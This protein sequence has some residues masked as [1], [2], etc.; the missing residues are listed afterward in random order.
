[1]QFSVIFSFSTS[2]KY[3]PYSAPSIFYT[4]KLSFEP[5]LVNK[6]LQGQ[7]VLSS[8]TERADGNSYL[9]KTGTC[10]LLVASVRHQMSVLKQFKAILLVL[11]MLLLP[12]LW[13]FRFPAATFEMQKVIEGQM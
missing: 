12:G 11:H 1:M 10:E 3:S 8:Q 4:Q 9:S 2:E 13:R 5:R 6:A 7:Y